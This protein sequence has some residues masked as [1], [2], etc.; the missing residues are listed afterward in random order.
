MVLSRNADQQSST[1]PKPKSNVDASEARAIRNNEELED[2]LTTATALVNREKEAAAAALRQA[3]R[4][5]LA[6]Q[7]I[8]LPAEA[9][10]IAD[11]AR[12]DL[13][14]ASV[15]LAL[16][17]VTQTV[18]C[19]RDRNFAEAVNAADIAM[20][21]LGM[22]T[23]EPLLN[24]V[25]FI[26]EHGFLETR[27]D[28]GI[29]GMIGE[30]RLSHIDNLLPG[31]AEPCTAVDVKDLSIQQFSEFFQHDRPVVIKGCARDWPALEK[32]PEASYLNGAYGCRTVPV[33]C[34]EIETGR[35]TEKFSS[36]GDV[37]LMMLTPSQ[38]A[39]QAVYLAQHPLFDYIPALESDII[40]PK[41]MQVTGKTRADL[42]NIWMGSPK[43]GSKLHFD[44]ADN[45]LVQVVGEK[46]VVLISPDQ[47]KCLYQASDTDNIS[48]VDAGR[49]DL[50]TFPQFRSVRGVTASLQPGDALYIP[51]FH[52][53][54]V[55]ALSSSISVNFWF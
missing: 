38:D 37:L 39:K 29:K 36:L 21:L 33:E 51:A 26:E 11:A 4:S 43:S 47:S 19:T 16:A 9:A 55:R 10:A 42:M 20:V 7:V 2:L 49:P 35:M 18:T 13:P 34:I 17:S 25:H 45:F 23:A 52:W 40:H 14:V 1:A 3:S 30:M 53:H 27:K 41:Y 28:T 48:P 15:A 50:D 46:K 31:L 6:R 54:W 22:P 5:R 32:W 12:R 44:S 24:I 8:Q